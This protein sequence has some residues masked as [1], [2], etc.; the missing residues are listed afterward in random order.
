MSVSGIVNTHFIVAYMLMH[1]GTDEQKDRILPRMASAEDVWAQGW[2]E[3]Q[4]GS[5]LAGLKSRA[6][7]DEARDHVVDEILQRGRGRGRGI[8]R[9]RRNGVAL[10]GKHDDRCRMGGRRCAVRGVCLP[11][12]R[13][14][15]HCSAT[16]A[17]SIVSRV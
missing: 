14:G 1:H 7:R 9:R 15:R 6:V 17:L 12:R 5:D 3:P 10:A 13:R 4:A 16:T 2:S 11:A 8:R